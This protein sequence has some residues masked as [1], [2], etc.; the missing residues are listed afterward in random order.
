M[1]K[2]LT[3]TLA[4]LSLNT[5]ANCQDFTGRYYADPAEALEGADA[6]LLW[7]TVGI[8]IDTTFTITQYDCNRI[9]VN[10]VHP[11]GGADG[12]ITRQLKVKITEEGLKQV[13]QQIVLGLD[14]NPFSDPKN[15]IK[16]DLL[17]K[18]SLTED[19]DLKYSSKLLLKKRCATF[20]RLE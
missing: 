15:G 5:F 10:Y 9:D 8:P 1:K 3:L 16:A 6:I 7:D 2:I 19:G 12:T 18:L 20:R 14:L 11:F 4:L 13:S 17:E